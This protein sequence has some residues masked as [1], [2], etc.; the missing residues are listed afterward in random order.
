MLATFLVIGCLWA[1]EP[2]GAPADN[3]ALK[4]AVQKLVRNL[5]ADTRNERAEA[6]N[7]LLK[8]GPPALD[9]LPS[10]ESQP[11]DNL[12]D[13]IKRIREKLQ[14]NQALLG[15]EA[16]TVTLQGRMKISKVLAEIQK[17]TGNKIADLP[18]AAGAAIPDPEITVRYNKTPFW[19]ALDSA[20]DDAQLSIYP[21]GQPMALQIIP[22]GP[23]DLPRSGRPALAGPLRI[24]PI[25]VL[26][27]R[28]LRVSSPAVLQ[29]GLEV[30]WEP[31]LQ[32][33]AIMQRMADV[34][35]V[36]SNGNTLAAENPQAENEPFINRGSSAVELDVA[37]AMP[38]RPVKEI[39]SLKGT[40]RAIILGKVETF[41]FSDLLKG[42]QEKRLA[43]ATVAL[44]EVRKNGD[45]WEVFVR[46]RFDDA[47]DALESHR[48]WVSQNEAFLEDASGKR[49]LPDSSETTLRTKN[50]IGVGY[51][52]ALPDFPKNL[53]FVYKTAGMIVT[54]DFPYAL[55]DIKMP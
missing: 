27:K 39:A 42:K 11:N 55:R 25:R 46:L 36:D 24:E 20:L 31:R 6:E 23:D 52:F 19:A 8:L 45:S 41:R 28:E 12:R 35:A 18:R 32:P 50:E 38:A 33:V 44:D 43:A 3:A 2:A 21:Y 7:A 51:V 48:N 5:D 15:L 34:K 49:I 30:A 53:T 4:A 47:G 16:S 13:A 26:A 17:Q 14:K 54:K 1:A 37:L 10:S 22:R 29:I 40:V 9:F